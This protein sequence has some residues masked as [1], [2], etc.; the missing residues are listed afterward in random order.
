MRSFSLVII[1][2]PEPIR[3]QSFYLQAWLWW[4]VG[5]QEVRRVGDRGEE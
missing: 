5:K 2:V 3:W 1:C 4:L